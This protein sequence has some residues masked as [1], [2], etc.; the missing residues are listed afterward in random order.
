MNLKPSEK[1]TAKLSVR[2][3]NSISISANQYIAVRE[4]GVETY[5]GAYEFTPTDEPQTIAI[6]NKRATSNITINPIPSNYGKITW[7]GSFLT[8]S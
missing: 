8:V 2:G 3:D 4:R 5:D 1:T 7:N 6:E